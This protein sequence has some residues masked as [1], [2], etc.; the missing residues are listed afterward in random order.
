[1]ILQ[2]PIQFVSPAPL[3]SFLFLA[4]SDL[5]IQ[6]PK[7]FFPQDVPIVYSL[8][9]FGSSDGYSSFRDIFLGHFTQPSST[10]NPTVSYFPWL[11]FS[12]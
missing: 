6:V 4:S 10:L 3:T 2:G 1:M 11:Y 5:L 12:P 8:I 7:L 9:S